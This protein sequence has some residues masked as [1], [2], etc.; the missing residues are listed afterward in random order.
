[1]EKGIVAMKEEVNWLKEE[2]RRKDE[3]INRLR[4][5]GRKNGEEINRL[6]EEGRKKEKEIDQ[7]F[8]LIGELQG[9]NYDLR[10]EMSKYQ[11][12]KSF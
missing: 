7:I 5:E 4:E 12:K 10:M 2:G 11:Q 1:M 8:W 3:A 6:C 9:E